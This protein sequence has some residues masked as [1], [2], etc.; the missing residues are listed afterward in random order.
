MDHSL[1]SGFDESTAQA[2]PQ[3]RLSLADLYKPLHESDWSLTDA[4]IRVFKFEHDHSPDLVKVKLE[5]IYLSGWQPQTNCK[6]VSYE[7]RSPLAT[8]R[9]HAN[10][11]ELEIGKN[12]YSFL[13]AYRDVERHEY[14]QQH[15]ESLG[16][17]DSASQSF[18]WIDQICI[19]QQDLHERNRQVQLMREIY[20][21]ATEVIAWLGPPEQML[22]EA[23]VDIG[24]G[25]QPQGGHDAPHHHLQR[26][27]YW[28]RLWIVQEILLA[29]GIRLMCG[30]VSLDWSRLNDWAS[31]F[32]SSFEEG[33]GGNLQA[34]ILY[35]RQNLRGGR[36]G[37][38][39][40][41]LDYCESSCKDLRDKVYALLGLLNYGSRWTVDYNSSPHEV[42]EETARIMADELLNP[43]RPVDIDPREPACDFLSG[44]RHKSLV[45]LYD[46][47][48]LKKVY[49]QDHVT[50][51][52]LLKSIWW[53]A[54][55]EHLKP[56]KGH[57]SARHNA[58]IP[59]DAEP[60]RR[61]TI[62]STSRDIP[63][64][65]I[66]QRETL[67]AFEALT[68]AANRVSDD[69]P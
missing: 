62:A 18:L 48:R 31:S 38:E 24:A 67:E 32:S 54:C 63:R 41:L 34:F 51:D 2:E 40:V 55:K 1:R 37:I 27:T 42:F 45:L 22:Q 46:Q 14:A 61:H 44:Q 11:V 28:T 26:C 64:S 69:L 57:L 47:M 6:A 58:I 29:R 43:L 4:E 25:S 65:A 52:Q 59:S 19:N 23:L 30:N 8:Q 50:F 21:N 13:R 56:P 53:E 10:G 33:K 5:T 68:I 35:R 7:W 39:D 17:I 12:L 9:I 36:L 3:T 15:P 66:E 60:L 49:E 20:G 16:L